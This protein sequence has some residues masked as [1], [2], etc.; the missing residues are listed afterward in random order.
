L[1]VLGAIDGNSNPYHAI[2]VAVDK[3]ESHIPLEFQNSG[4]C[5]EK[6]PGFYAKVS[7]EFTASRQTLP[8]IEP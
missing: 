4:G 3:L 1:L 8:V 2:G 5:A 6:T 7:P